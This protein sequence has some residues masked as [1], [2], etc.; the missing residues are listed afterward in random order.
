MAAKEADIAKAAQQ[1][2]GNPNAP[3]PLSIWYDAILLP[4]EVPI[5]K[6]TKLNDVLV[7]GGK[8]LNQQYFH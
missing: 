6:I 2:T 1:A 8:I 5:S 4:N 3:V 7:F